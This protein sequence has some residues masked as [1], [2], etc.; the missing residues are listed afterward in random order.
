MYIN[1]SLEKECSKVFER[2]PLEA[3]LKRE[4]VPQLIWTSQVTRQFPRDVIANTEKKQ[5][6]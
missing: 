6:F 1:N 4:S 5:G 3:V 2:H